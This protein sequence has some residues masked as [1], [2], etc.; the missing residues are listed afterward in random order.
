MKIAFLFLIISDIYHEPTWIDFLKGHE[1][2][3][4]VYIHSKDKMPKDSYFKRCEIPAKIPT[5]WSKIM[6]AF[7]ELLREALKDPSN[8]KF[9]FLSESSIPLKTFDQAYNHLL[10]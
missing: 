1:D 9:V 3:Y 8:E 2:K 10:S 4:S 6:K 5:S 7:I